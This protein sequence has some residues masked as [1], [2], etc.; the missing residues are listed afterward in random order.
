MHPLAAAI[1]KYPSLARIEATNLI[2]GGLVIRNSPISARIDIT[3]LNFVG[4]ADLK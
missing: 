4:C 1:R 2:S 3:N